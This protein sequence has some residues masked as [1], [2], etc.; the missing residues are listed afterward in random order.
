MFSVSKQ[1]VAKQDYI[2][3]LCLYSGGWVAG[4]LLALRFV[5]QVLVQQTLIHPLQ[6]SAG[7]YIGHNTGIAL[8]FLLGGLTFGVGTGLLLAWNG[9][10]SGIIASV[11]ARHYGTLFIAAGLLPHGIPEALA[12]ILLGAC[13]LSLGR[14][15]R[16]I[17]FPSPQR[18][19][20]KRSG[21][22]EALPGI[23]PDPALRTRWQNFLLLIA[24]SLVLLI[25][26]GLLESSLSFWLLQLPG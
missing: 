4:I 25:I 20:A 17:C 10:L 26:A 2:L 23:L 8:L 3:S 13:G 18:S 24:M 22:R 1:L 12:W 21:T 19:L 7:F 9:C 14:Q 11:V 6:Q 5:P 16:H 15:F